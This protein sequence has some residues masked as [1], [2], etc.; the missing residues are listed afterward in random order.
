MKSGSFKL[1]GIVK[2]EIIQSNEK[3]QEIFI[4]KMSALAYTWFIR[5]Q[6]KS[7]GKGTGNNIGK[8]RIYCEI[9]LVQQKH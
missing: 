2:W 8:L 4:W 5:F 6:R 3:G 1:A 7:N 9:T